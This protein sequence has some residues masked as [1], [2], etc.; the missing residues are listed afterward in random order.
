MYTRYFMVIDGPV[1]DAFLRLRTERIAAEKV[2]LKF[3]KTIGAST[4]YGRDSKSYAFSFKK[5]KLDEVRKSPLWTKHAR[6]PKA[7]YPSKKNKNAKELRD[8]FALLPPFPSLNAALESVGLYP[9]FPA[10][11]ENSCSYSPWIRFYSLSSGVIIIGVPWRDMPKKD[12]D[13]YKR[14]HAAGTHSS[15]THEYLSWMPHESL[16]EMKEWE[17][18]KL[19]DD[20]GN[21]KGET[22]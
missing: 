3:M 5:E 15:G 8:A 4:C 10:L 2:M 19:I 11:I 16:K 21:E 9:G 1:W 17:A 13:A 20:I 14:E 12:M 7:F 22:K 18:L 6:I